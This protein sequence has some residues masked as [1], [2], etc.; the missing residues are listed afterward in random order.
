MNQDCG[1][2]SLVIPLG[3]LHNGQDLRGILHLHV[4]RYLGLLDD[5]QQTGEPAFDLSDDLSSLLLPLSLPRHLLAHPGLPTIIIEQPQEQDVVI[6][7]RL[8]G[9][10]SGSEVA[11][12]GLEQVAE[13]L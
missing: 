7:Q 2:L 1:V 13:R 6:P 3:T 4:Q 5:G 12:L 11:L 9:L 10:I 8:V